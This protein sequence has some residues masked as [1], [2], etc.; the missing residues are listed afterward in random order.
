M[1]KID[2]TMKRHEPASM[3]QVPQGFRGIYAHAVQVRTPARLLVISGQIG[4]EP[5]GSVPVSFAGQCERA[6]T[7]VEA[8]LADA[9][10]AVSD[11][12]KVNYYLTRPADL[13]S[14]AEIRNRRWASESPP[15]V[16]TLVVAALAR[17]ELL[18][19]IEVT[20]ASTCP[21][22]GVAQ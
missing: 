11:I 7:N 5:D 8:L 18:I 16:T 17:P 14:L 13:P 2:D 4:V 3:W 19:E 6:M 10:M 9:D 1:R 20:A 21:E 22:G 12:I 15:A